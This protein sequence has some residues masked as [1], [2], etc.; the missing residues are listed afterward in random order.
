M[1]LEEL[2]YKRLA[3]SEKLARHLAVYNSAPAVFTPE[4]PDASQEGWKGRIYGQLPSASEEGGIGYRTEFNRRHGF[5]PA[6][7]EG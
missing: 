5:C 1:I 2:I 6:A 7:E 3:G 4:P